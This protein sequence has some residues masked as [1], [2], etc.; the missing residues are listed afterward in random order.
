MRMLAEGGIEILATAVSLF[1]AVVSGAFAFLTLR[2]T[3]DSSRAQAHKDIS[4]LY[5]SLVVFRKEHPEVHRLSSRWDASNFARIYTQA[6]DE[7]RQWVLYYAYVELCLGFCNAVLHAENSGFLDPGA[8]KN[9]YKPLVKLLLTEHYP[10]VE[11]L[12]KHR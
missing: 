8:F 6:S 12:L 7:D 10:I 11:D 4:A 5:D 2:Q 9:Q 1:G 3:R